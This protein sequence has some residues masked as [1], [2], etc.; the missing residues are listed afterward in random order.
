[1]KRYIILLWVPAAF[2]VYSC[3]KKATP[4]P[5]GGDGGTTPVIP[6]VDTTATI[7]GFSPAT[8]GAGAELTITGTNFGTSINNVTVS[9]GGSGAITPKS[10][11][12]TQIIIVVPVGSPSGKITVTV[13][14]QKAVN[15]LSVFTFIPAYIVKTIGIS[16][17][18]VGVDD[19]FK[20][21]VAQLY[22][23]GNKVI[24][25]SGTGNTMELSGTLLGT[26]PDALGNP[27][28]TLNYLNQPI[29]NGTSPTDTSG[30]TATV[31][32][33][34]GFDKKKTG[35]N[36]LNLVMCK[37][38]YYQEPMS[39]GYQ[40][41][42]TYLKFK[43]TAGTKNTDYGTAFVKK[44]FGGNISVADVEIAAPQTYITEDQ[45]ISAGQAGISTTGGKTVLSD[46]RSQ[47][48]RSLFTTTS[49]GV[50]FAKPLT[51]EWVNAD[52]GTV[53]KQGDYVYEARFNNI[54]TGGPD[55]VVE[56]AD[57]LSRVYLRISGF[58]P[59]VYGFNS[60]RLFIA[61]DGFYDGSLQLLFHDKQTV[62]P[63]LSFI[64]DAYKGQ[65]LYLQELRPL[66]QHY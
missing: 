56:P 35:Y 41:N 58:D 7:T 61:N 4:P 8:A 13:K 37:L 25:K 10:V 47:F 52:N 28:G 21:T 32:R 64:R 57:S 22:G 44:L 63:T 30:I 23:G 60:L 5:N 6:I 48:Y 24:L 26:I 53:T 12:A 39:P 50:T 40:S 3:S 34:K 43:K 33:L 49:S 55:Q 18:L 66:W 46:L 27:D 62:A 15:S 9:I 19:N 51:W 45:V 31:I 1:M 42:V 16:R 54:K 65:D 17:I 20:I 59:A 36:Q 38:V 11:S 29:D 2:L 14:N